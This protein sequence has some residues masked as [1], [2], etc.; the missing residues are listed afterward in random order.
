MNILKTKYTLK[1][2][3]LGKPIIAFHKKNPIRNYI[4][5]TDMDETSEKRNLK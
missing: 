1:E 2:V 4:V 5:R 3:F